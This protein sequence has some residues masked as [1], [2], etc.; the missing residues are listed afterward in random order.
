MKSRL[1]YADVSYTPVKRQAQQ[2][3][4]QLPA[5]RWGLVTCMAIERPIWT[6]A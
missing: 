4:A 5:R 6:S 2:Q 3:Q 1:G